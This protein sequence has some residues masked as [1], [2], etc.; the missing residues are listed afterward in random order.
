MKYIIEKEWAGSKP[1][2]TIIEV[3][4]IHPVLASNVR[5]IKEDVKTEVKEEVEKEAP[6]RV[7]KKAE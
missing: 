6:K 3:D 4:K 2:G 5:L 7:T 1:K